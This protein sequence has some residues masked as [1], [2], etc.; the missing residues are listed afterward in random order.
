MGAKQ[1][2]FEAILAQFVRPHGFAGRL[3]GW[4]M[5]LRPSNRKR[6]RWAVGLLEVQPRDR[7]LEV[8]FG[9]GIAIR[10]LARRATD[11][12][13]C[14]IDHSEVMVRQATARNRVAVEHGRVDLRLGSALDLGDFS[15]MFDKV[16][17]VNNLGM[18]PDPDARL[19][20][21]RGAVRP[22]GRVAIVSQPRCPGA[23]AATTERVG[24]E[25][26]RL[27]RDAGF[28]RIRRELLN[29]R[30]PV[31]CV[32]AEAPTAEGSEPSEHDLR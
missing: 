31:V 11:G 15:D 3:T 28:I 7:V 27:L 20:E 21:L 2:L 14:G 16:L 4:K 22:G 17:V 19:K 25:T 8:G 9:P 26:E 32:L 13:V 5:A 18:W 30:P 29:L 24:V 1:R 12:V 23:T 6:N 10:Q